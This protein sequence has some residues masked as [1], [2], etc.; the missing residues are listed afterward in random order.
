VAKCR[1]TIKDLYQ[2]RTMEDVHL[3]PDGR[4]VALTLATSN[5][6]KLEGSNH[7][8][9]LCSFGGA[10]SLRTGRL[11]VDAP[12]SVLRVVMGALGSAE[13]LPFVQSRNIAPSV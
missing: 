2:F 8:F 6:A 4:V 12:T 1:F 9:P 10:V 7:E 3:S 5:L 13:P 11:F